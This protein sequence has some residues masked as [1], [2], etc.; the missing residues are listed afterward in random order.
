MSEPQHREPGQE[1]RRPGRGPADC[2]SGTV[3]GPAGIRRP[4][5]ATKS[6]WTAEMP[7]SC[8][9]RRGRRGNSRRARRPRFMIVVRFSRPSPRHEEA[10]SVGLS[11]EAGLAPSETIAQ[12]R[13]PAGRGSVHG[14]SRVHF[15]PRCAAPHYDS[16]QRA[17]H[18]SNSVPTRSI[19][20][21]PR[22]R[23][24]FPGT[25][26]SSAVGLSPLRPGALGSQTPTRRFAEAAIG[27][28]SVGS[29]RHFRLGR[30]VDA[31]PCIGEPRGHR[32]PTA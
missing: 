25:A 32:H 30:T 18:V 17:P 14:F 6:V 2:T 10:K 28:G 29:R 8:S 16:S 19:A 12:K 5:R 23:P 22:S 20:N 11:A 3:G 1:V 21:M 4:K 26:G 24:L 7:F 31:A 13:G 27:S 15:R 9:Y